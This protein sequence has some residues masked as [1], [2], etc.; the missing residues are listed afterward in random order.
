MVVEVYPSVNSHDFTNFAGAAA[1]CWVST[2]T[3]NDVR[4]VEDLVKDSLSE[5]DWCVSKVIS[6]EVV[7]A[8]NYSQKKEGKDFFDQ[9]LGDGFVI[10]LDRAAREVVSRDSGPKSKCL[11]VE[12]YKIYLRQVQ[13]G[14]AFSLFSVKDDQWAVGVTP[15]GNDF[16]PLW[17]NQNEILGWSQ[18][19]PDYEARSLTV[20][21]LCGGKL[22]KT[23]DE[24][25]AWVAIGV[26]DCLVTMHPSFLLAELST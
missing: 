11:T 12:E 16:M 6:L 20:D 7:T 26:E 22:L 21:D 17:R 1:G 18:F 10:H 25:L 24:E 9:A 4:D 19:W 8:G 15:Q 23:L 5:K 2:K 3:V 14:G 13:T